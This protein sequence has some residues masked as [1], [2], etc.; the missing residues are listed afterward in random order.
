MSKP[1]L[2]SLLAP[3]GISPI[4]IRIGQDVVKGYERAAFA[5]AWLRYLPPETDKAGGPDV[6]A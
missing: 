5:D 4:N 2:A 3:F 6:A 1:Q